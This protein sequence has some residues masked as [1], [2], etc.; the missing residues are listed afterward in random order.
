MKKAIVAIFALCA[1]AIGLAGCKFE[2]PD[3]KQ[4]GNP[5]TVT[6]AV[7][8]QKFRTTA[9]AQTTVEQQPLTDDE[10]YLGALKDGGISVGDESA[11]VSLAEEICDFRRQYSYTPNQMAVVITSDNDQLSYTQNEVEF[12]IR[13]ATAVYCPEVG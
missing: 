12:I 10:K 6:Q 8:A 1:L 11:A 2:T 3:T 9:P 4:L 5:A 7:D 13:I